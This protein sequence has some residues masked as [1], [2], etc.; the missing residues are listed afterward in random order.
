MVNG[1][2]DL[3]EGDEVYV[4]REDGLRSLVFRVSDK[5][6]EDIG[7]TETLAVTLVS[8]S[9]SL[10]NFALTGTTADST[11]HMQAID[12]EDEYQLFWKQLH[13]R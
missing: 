1:V 13:I 9:E 6:V 10:P 7:I 12:D 11:V 3:E 2:R 4:T 5:Q 8:T